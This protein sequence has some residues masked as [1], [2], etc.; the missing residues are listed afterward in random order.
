[1]NAMVKNV[2]LFAIVGVLILLTGVLQ[3]WNAAILI[4]RK[5]VV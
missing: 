4:D 3:S 5:S 2:G 1:M